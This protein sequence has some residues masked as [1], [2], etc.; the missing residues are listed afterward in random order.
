[1]SHSLSQRR[2]PLFPLAA[3]KFPARRPPHDWPLRTF[4]FQLPPYPSSVFQTGLAPIQQGFNRLRRAD[5]GFKL[6][7]I[8]AWTATTHRTLDSPSGWLAPCPPSS[9]RPGFHPGACPPGPKLI[10]D[11]HRFSSHRDFF[12]LLPLSQRIFAPS[13]SLQPAAQNAQP[14]PD[15][16]IE[17]S[18]SIQTN[19]NHPAT[20]D[21]L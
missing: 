1:V 6:P 11:L 4:L 12:S 18:D 20:S 10:L 19:P 3:V 13:Q 8:P 16:I 5:H 2:L 21:T 9:E 14:H 7:R 15:A 17:S